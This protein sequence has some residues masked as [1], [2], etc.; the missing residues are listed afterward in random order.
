M[1]RYLLC[2]TRSFVLSTNASNV[3]SWAK[4]WLRWQ[5][6]NTL[7]NHIWSVILVN[8]LKSWVQSWTV[9]TVIWF[10]A[11]NQHVTRSCKIKIR[12]IFL[13]IHPKLVFNKFPNWVPFFYVVVDSL[14]KA[15]MTPFFLLLAGAWECHQGPGIGWSA[16]V[17][18]RLY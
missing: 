4:S 11:K 16:R 13:L 15:S 6:N 1:L 9:V 18:R 10:G 17:A 14:Y 2:W 12:L 3:V 8:K 7:R 5:I